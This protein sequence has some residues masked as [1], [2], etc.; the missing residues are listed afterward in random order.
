MVLLVVG[1][2]FVN[3]FVQFRHLMR[4]F[5]SLVSNLSVVHDGNCVGYLLSRLCYFLSQF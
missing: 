4:D 3:M 5:L 2:D 1:S